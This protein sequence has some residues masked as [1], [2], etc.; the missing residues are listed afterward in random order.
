MRRA[1]LPV[2]AILPLLAS[3]PAKAV[4]EQNFNADTTGDLVALCSAD[5]KDPMGTA[6]LNFCHGFM[7]GAVRVMQAQGIATRGTKPFCL[8][9]P[10]PSRTQA[11]ANFVKWAQDTPSHMAMRPID[12]VYSYLGATYPCKRKK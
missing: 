10:T 11:I 7:V 5:A 2:L 9:E 8:P 1:I 6:A 4:T 12:A 3:Q